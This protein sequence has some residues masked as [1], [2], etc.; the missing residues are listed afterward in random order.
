MAGRSWRRTE[1]TGGDTASSA[2]TMTAEFIGD[3]GLSFPCTCLC[4]NPRSTTPRPHSQDP[5][6][7]AACPPSVVVEQ[8]HERAAELQP[9]APG[10][11]AAVL[12]SLS[13]AE[14]ERAYLVP[15]LYL[16]WASVSTLF[17]LW[18]PSHRCPAIEP[19]VSTCWWQPRSTCA[20]TTVSFWALRAGCAPP[21]RARS[22]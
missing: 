18:D 5:R 16:E 21:A 19:P 2:Q 6:R 11:V 9:E 4:S 17:L 20:P 7:L 13:K 15:V 10:V 1:T 14:S 3:F 8:P 12:Q 22:R